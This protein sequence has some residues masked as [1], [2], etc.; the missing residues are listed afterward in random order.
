M[1]ILNITTQ[2]PNSTG[3]GTYLSEMVKAFSKKGYRQSVV[4]GVYKDDKVSFGSDVA[5]YPVYYSTEKLPYPIL[6]MSNSM[7]YVSTLYSE[8]DD[9][10][11]EQL[12]KA[13]IPVIQKAVNEICPDIIICH[14]LYLLTAI[15]RKYFPNQKVVGICHGSDLRQLMTCGFQRDMIVHY[16][17]QLDHIHALHNKQREQIL[18]LFNVSED[19]VTVIGSGYNSEIFNCD[20]T[21]YSNTTNDQCLRIAYAGKL[22]KEKGTLSLFS[23]L[24][25]VSEDISAPPFKLM[26]AGGCSVPEVSKAANGIISSNIFPLEYFGP[27]NQT[28]LADMFRQCDLFVL[29]SFYEGLP[30]VLIEAMACGLKPICTDLPGVREWI[31]STIPESNVKFIDMPKLES[32]DSPCIDG[33]QEFENSLADAIKEVLNYLKKHGRNHYKLNI[34][35]TSMVSWNKVAE[36]A[37]QL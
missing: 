11:L 8:M 3:S 10:K 15:V 1:N 13:F 32:I 22:C 29:P 33:I 21:K 19:K 5:F 26:L 9:T 28:D 18:N 23:S 35:D 27:L 6:G 2:K 16:I 34:P 31:E 25:K 36:R 17:S 12:I 30:L 7:P 37:V 4:A 24:M 14:H 20:D